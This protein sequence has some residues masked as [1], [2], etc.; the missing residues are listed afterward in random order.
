MEITLLNS[1]FSKTPAE[2]ELS[3][4]Y[5]NILAAILVQIN[6]AELIAKDLEVNIT[7]NLIFKVSKSTTTEIRLEAV[8]EVTTG[9]TEIILYSINTAIVSVKSEGATARYVVNL[10]TLEPVIG[11]TAQ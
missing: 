2:G 4:E 7:D 3:A 9:I 5:S 11:P 6:N 8:G 10:L 1:I